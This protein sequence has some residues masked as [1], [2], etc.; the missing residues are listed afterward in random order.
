LLELYMSLFL[1][2][3]NLCIRI[4]SII[5]EIQFVNVEVFTD[6]IEIGINE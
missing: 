1:G 3:K 2:L 4:F 5:D 6:S